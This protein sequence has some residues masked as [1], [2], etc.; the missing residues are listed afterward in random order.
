MTSPALLAITKPAAAPGAAALRLAETAAR[1]M[2]EAASGRAGAYT[3]WLNQLAAVAS[4]A[5]L[6]LPAMVDNSAT[7]AQLAGLVAAE[8]IAQAGAGLF[9][10]LAQ[11]SLRRARAD[12]MLWAKLHR[13]VYHDIRLIRHEFADIDVLDMER[14]TAQRVAPIQLL[15]GAEGALETLTRDPLVDGVHFDLAKLAETLTKYTVVTP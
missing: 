10:V 13:R 3:A 5:A 15:P 7:P 9:D 1:L 14:A 11:R 2:A 4:R 12:A 6:L 8:R